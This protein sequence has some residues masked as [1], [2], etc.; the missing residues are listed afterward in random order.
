MSATSGGPQGVLI[1]A[2]TSAIAH[3]TAKLFASE[4]ARLYLVGRNPKKLEA[5][6]RGAERLGAT[7][8]RTHRAPLHRT[9]SRWPPALSHR[10][11]SRA[12]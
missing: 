9:V 5:V 10:D 1:V 6:A 11:A 2:A 4:G 7:D 8:V 12:N 3:E